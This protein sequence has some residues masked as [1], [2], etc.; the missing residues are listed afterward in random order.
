MLHWII[1]SGLGNDPDD[2]LSPLLGF[3][4]HMMRI[5]IAVDKYPN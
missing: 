2:P 1:I 3:L 4:Q 5:L